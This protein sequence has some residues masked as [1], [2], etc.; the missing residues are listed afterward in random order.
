VT[1]KEQ[2]FE[3]IQKHGPQT[4]ADLVKKFKA[5]A[6]SMRRTCGELAQAGKIVPMPS[7][8][9]RLWGISGDARETLPEDLA[10]GPRAK[11]APV[12]EAGKK[13]MPKPT[14]VKKVDADKPADQKDWRMTDFTF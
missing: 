9:G 3:Y 4:N 2:V 11:K 5:K 10:T 14:P 13:F 6:A 1:L 12:D 7:K 8:E